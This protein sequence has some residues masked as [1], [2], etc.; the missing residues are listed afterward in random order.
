[1]KALVLEQYN[2]FTYNDI[3]KPV[4]TDGEVLIRIMAVAICGSDVH[5]YDG[6]SGR[7]KPPLV[8]GHEASGVVEAVGQD[9]TKVAAGDKVV[10][11]SGLYCRDCYYCRRG[12]S[13]MC[14]DGK[15]FGVSCDDYHLEGAMCE[16]ISVPDYIVYKISDAISFEQAALVEPVSIALHAVNSTHIRIND[17]AI[18]FGAGTI[19]LMI[20]KTLKISSC[21][22][23]IIVD[24]DETKLRMAKN[25]GVDVCIKADETDVV[26]E[27]R[28]LTGGNGADIAFEA[29][30]VSDT[31]N[32]A[33]A[34]LKKGG[35]LTMV[36][37]VSAKIEFPLQKVVI[38]EIRLT[39]SYGCA[40]EYE[41]AIEMMTEGR[42][43]VSD[44]VSAV[45]PLSEGQQWFDRLHA[46]EKGL[47]KV[48][49]RP[50]NNESGK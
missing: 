43:D 21:G 11:N 7:R 25:M 13:N 10:F 14:V 36:G 24:I 6:R 38:N 42:I 9:V 44:C 35:S 2:Q 1:M 48:V 50:D 17:T 46:A 41:T 22:R 39:G 40:T 4:P 19:G 20:L 26:S 45:A 28:R 37:N 27:I 49:L 34:C 12:K 5:G 3:K 33:I 16:Y 15:I 30:G 47:L 18:I 31:I 32:N 23:V 8:L 29:V